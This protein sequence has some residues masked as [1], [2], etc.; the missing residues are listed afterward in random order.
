MC[1]IVAGLFRLSEVKADW[2]AS[3]LLQNMPYAYEEAWLYILISRSSEN[4][5]G[6]SMRTISLLND[7]YLNFLPISYKDT[8]L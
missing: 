5:Y 4:E 8:E 2:M 3:N 1:T 7:Y 6:P